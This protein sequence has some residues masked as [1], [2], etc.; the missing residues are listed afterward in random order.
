MVHGWVKSEKALRPRLK[1]YDGLDSAARTI[2]TSTLRVSSALCTS[3]RKLIRVPFI[4]FC[5][6]Q[7]KVNSKAVDCCHR[8]FTR[9]EVRVYPWLA[10]S[11][12]GR[13]PHSYGPESL[14]LPPQEGRSSPLDNHL[15]STHP[16]TPKPP[17]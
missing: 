13:G 16:I 1:G 12:Q 17:T 2:S 6:F 15:R 10:E 5:R 9:F 4:P 14:D 8:G 3:R 7:S 11:S